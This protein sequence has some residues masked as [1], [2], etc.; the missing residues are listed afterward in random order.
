MKTS[1]YFFHF[2]NVAKNIHK[3]I[4][5]AKFGYKQDTKIKMYSIKFVNLMHK[6][7]R[8]KILKY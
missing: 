1:F 4:Y 6:Q 8:T 5:L 7:N 2:C 3:L